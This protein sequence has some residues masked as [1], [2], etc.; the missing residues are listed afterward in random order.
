MPHTAH[1]RQSDHRAEAPLGCSGRTLSRCVSVVGVRRVHVRVRVCA[2]P[3]IG[4][5]VNEFVYMIRLSVCFCSL[6]RR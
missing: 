3:R 5:H 1:A 4:V 2:H 6:P